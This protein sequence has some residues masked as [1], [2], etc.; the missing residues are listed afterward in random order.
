M[1][2]MK[3]KQ[4]A[5]MTLLEG[6]VLL[7][8]EQKLDLVENFPLFTEEQI[9]ALGNFLAA[10]ERL[11]QDFGEDIQKGV[12]KVLNDIVGEKVTQNENTVYVGVGKAQ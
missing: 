1:N 10:E 9:D 5:V 3:E 11:R 8:Y 12:E 7:S 4:N 2:T 6:S